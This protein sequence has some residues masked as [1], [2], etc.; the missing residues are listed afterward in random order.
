MN[1]DGTP[2]HL[3][4]P[5][6]PDFD[7]TKPPPPELAGRQF[8]ATVINDPHEYVPGNGR[9]TSIQ[10]CN[11]GAS[12]FLLN[13]IMLHYGGSLTVDYVRADHATNQLFHSF[14][15]VVDV[16]G[17]NVGQNHL[18]N[19]EPLFGNNSVDLI[20]ARLERLLHQFVTENANAIPGIDLAQVLGL[21]ASSCCANRQKGS[22]AG[23][24]GPASGTRLRFRDN[25]GL[26]PR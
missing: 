16:R 12:A 10:A 5:G 9:R 14:G 24:Y 20:Y 6:M 8:V 1:A 11:K 26:A 13:G 15:A 19:Q 18:E 4:R 21:G 23:I 22:R 25:S 17:E 3:G 2:T 7:A